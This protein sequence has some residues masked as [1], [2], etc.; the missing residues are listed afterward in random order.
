MK[1][2]ADSPPPRHDLQTDATYFVS[3]AFRC[4]ATAF[5]YVG[6]IP[7]SPFTFWFI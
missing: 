6:E 5:I 7:Q 3:F 1:Q 2:R 4:L